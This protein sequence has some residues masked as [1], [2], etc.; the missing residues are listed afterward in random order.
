MYCEEKKQ[1]LIAGV[2][3]G[4]NET[5]TIMIRGKLKDFN[6]HSDILPAIRRFTYERKLKILCNPNEESDYNLL[7]INT[8]SLNKAFYDFSQLRSRVFKY[9]KVAFIAE[10]KKLRFCLAQDK[11]FGC[12]LHIG[13]T[14]QNKKMN[15]AEIHEFAPFDL[16]DQILCVYSIADDPLSRKVH[17]PKLS[18]YF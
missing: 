8:E 13:Y 18:P 2:F 12:Y 1:E 10:G 4:S 17:V 5:T 11:E 9:N 3:E 14:N 6:G 16:S 15:I 7:N